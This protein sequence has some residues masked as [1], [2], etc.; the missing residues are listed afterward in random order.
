MEGH[1]SV[2]TILALQICR[3]LD[4][5]EAD[6]FYLPMYI[7]CYMWPVMGWADGPW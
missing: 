6:F 3:T 1:C 5:E 4:P 2:C 7:S